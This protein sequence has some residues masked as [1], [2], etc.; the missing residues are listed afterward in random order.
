MQLGQALFLL[1]VAA[2][3]LALISGLESYEPSAEFSPHRTIP[4]YCR[5]C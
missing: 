3:M 2:L 5:G 1:V 4:E